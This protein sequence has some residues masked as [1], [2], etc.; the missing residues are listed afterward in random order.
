MAG[1]LNNCVVVRATHAAAATNETYTLIR[2]VQFQDAMCFS[3]S[4]GAG[5]VTVANT[6]LAAISSAMN[7]GAGDQTVARTT[8]AVLATKNLAVGAVLTF[9]PSAGTLDF[10][11]YAFLSA[12]GVAG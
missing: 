6:A 12:P 5:T 8:Q 4:A 10:E 1:T 7:C 9:I 11:C 3:T 2:G